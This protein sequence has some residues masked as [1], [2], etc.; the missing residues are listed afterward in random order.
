MTRQE[1]IDQFE[2]YKTVEKDYNSI[3][4][5]FFDNLRKY[6]KGSKLSFNCTFKSELRKVTSVIWNSYDEYTVEFENGDA[7][8][9]TSDDL[10]KMLR[11]SME[12]GTRFKD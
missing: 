7:I 10:T 1:L 12:Y 2:D 3:K 8:V 6:V 9:I 4:G 11:E 5:E